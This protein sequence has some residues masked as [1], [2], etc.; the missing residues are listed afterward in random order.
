MV[1]VKYTK[2]IAKS[3]SSFIN[4]GL[5]EIQQIAENINI[6]NH[7]ITTHADAQTPNAEKYQNKKNY[8]DGIIPIL[9]NN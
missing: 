8:Y 9:L 3:F 1:Q 2:S 4:R 6:K 7:K 5:E